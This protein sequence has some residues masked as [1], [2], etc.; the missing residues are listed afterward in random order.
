MYVIIPVSNEDGLD[1]TITTLASVKK[2]ALVNLAQG[3]DETP[4]FYDDWQSTEAEFIDHV[5]LANQQEDDLDFINEGIICLVRRE[6]ETIAELI[7]AFKFRELDEK[8][9]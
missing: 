4:K 1:A 6:E 2:W 8:S 3:A 7:S 9:F 5:I